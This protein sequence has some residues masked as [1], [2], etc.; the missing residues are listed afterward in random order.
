MLAIGAL[1]V[2]PYDFRQ[3]LTNSAIGVI[4]CLSFVVIVGFVGQISILQLGLAG[5]AG[6]IISKLALHAGIGFPVGLITAI[7]GAV[8]LGTAGAI[9]ALRVR[10]VTLAIVTLAPAW[11]LQEFVFANPTIGGGVT[12]AV[13]PSPHLFGLDLGPNAAFPINASS[14]PSPAFGGICVIAAMIVGMLVAGLRRSRTGT[15]MLAVRSN[16]RAAAAAGIDVRREKLIAFA[17]AS[18]VAGLAGGLYAYDFGSVSGTNFGV[19]PALG[20]LAFAYLGGITTVSGAV[21]GGLLVTQGIGFVALNKAF[22]VPLSYQLL[23]GGIALIVTIMMNPVGVAGAASKA[24]R[25]LPTRTRS[26]TGQRPG[27]RRRVA[28]PGA[29]GH[30]HSASDNDNDGGLVTAALEL[31]Q[32]SVSYGGLRALVNVDLTVGEGQL[33]GLIGPN[34]AGKT[35]L[36]DAATGYTPATGRAVLVVKTCPRCGP[37][38]ERDGGSREHGREPSSSRISR[39][40]R[41]SRWPPDISAWTE[42]VREIFGGRRHPNADADAALDAVGLE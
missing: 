26:T 8:V 30:I 14:P 36:I 5:V 3:A 16:E 1:L 27:H 7:G 12:A 21:I 39:C 40:T 11:V 13:V 33:V 22:G 42:T 25:D 38:A 15:R 41:T 28:R 19:L 9:P 29:H 17:I 18:G 20:F 24:F 2:F 4:L 32:L 31:E 35:T 6:V 34:G 23:V 10:G 37:I